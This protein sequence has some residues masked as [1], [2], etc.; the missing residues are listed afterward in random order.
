MLF[1]EMAH[2]VATGGMRFQGGGARH[3]RRLTT[4]E[5]VLAKLV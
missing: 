2:G 1:K 5:T 4:L 3:V